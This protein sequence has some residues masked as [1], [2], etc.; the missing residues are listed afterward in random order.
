MSAKILD[1]ATKGSKKKVAVSGTAK[2]ED[3][4]LKQYLSEVK[5]RA[6]EIFLERG[7]KHGADIN[8]WVRAEVEIRKKYKIKG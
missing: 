6:Y 4:N 3:I 5:K 1:G 7:A 8:D 2:S